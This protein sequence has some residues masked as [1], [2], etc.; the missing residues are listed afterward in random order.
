VAEAAAGKISAAMAAESSD[1]RL[2]KIFSLISSDRRTRG[3]QSPP[4]KKLGGT[5]LFS[6]L[7][8]NSSKLLKI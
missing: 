3:V 6:G 4:H 2:D 8:V 1:T 5:I 7:A